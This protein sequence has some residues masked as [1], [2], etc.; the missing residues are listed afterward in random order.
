VRFSAWLVSAIFAGQFGFAADEAGDLGG[1]KTSYTAKVAAL[2]DKMAAVAELPKGSASSV[3]LRCF[4]T[5]GNEL[6][7]GIEQKLTISAPFK[8][9]VKV[10]DD[11]DHYDDIFPDFEDIHIVSKEGNRSI[12]YWEQLIPVPF[13]PN[14]KYEMIYLFSEPKADR[15]LYR[16]QLRKASKILASDGF[17]VIAADGETATRY[18]E[19]DFFDAEWGSGKMFGKQ[20]LWRDAVEG[21]ALS[22]LGIKVKSEKPDFSGAKVRRE[23]KKIL[24]SKTYRDCVEQRVSSAELFK[25]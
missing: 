21:T 2:A 22:D 19:V 12:S 25:N 20:R 5:E 14:V 1:V 16:Y 8:A 24:E 23:S 17:I 13:V 4:T 15:K 18:Y 10:I 9:V 7:I 11:I 6:Y 3:D